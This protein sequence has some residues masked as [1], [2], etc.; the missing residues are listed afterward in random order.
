MIEQTETLK[1]DGRLREL[2]KGSDHRLEQEIQAYSRRAQGQVGSS[3]GSPRPTD[4]VVG[5]A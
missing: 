1:S 5:A 4:T 2:V 3:D